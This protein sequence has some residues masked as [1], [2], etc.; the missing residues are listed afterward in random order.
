[1]RGGHFL[2]GQGRSLGSALPYLW[3]CHEEGYHRI[4]FWRALPDDWS[5][6]STLRGSPVSHFP[7]ARYVA[8]NAQN[9]PADSRDPLLR[10]TNREIT[11]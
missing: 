3:K 7:R 10:S 8:A 11:R 6:Q 5:N 2:I 1:M 9:A 4:G